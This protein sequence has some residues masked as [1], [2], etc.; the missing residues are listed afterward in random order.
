MFR[1]R[2]ASDGLSPDEIRHD[3]Q[4]AWRKW[5]QAEEQNR[6]FAPSPPVYSL[7]WNLIFIDLE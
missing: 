3:S 2:R 5:V 1:S 4:A 6:Y 7:L